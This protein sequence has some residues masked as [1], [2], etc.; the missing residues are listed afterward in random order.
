MVAVRVEKFDEDD[1]LFGD[2]KTKKVAGKMTS[3]DEDDDIPHGEVD[4]LHDVPL[5]MKAQIGAVQ[6]SMKEILALKPGAVVEFDKVV[7]ESM[8][9]IIGGRLMCR[10]EI[11]VVNERYGIRISEVIRAEDSEKQLKPL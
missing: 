8:D 10:G 5:S 6:K 3:I 9:V 1:D 2:Q 4:Y 7:G 11:V